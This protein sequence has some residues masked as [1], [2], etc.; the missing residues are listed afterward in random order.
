[1]SLASLFIFDRKGQITVEF[2]LLHYVQLTKLI[3]SR[4]KY[5]FYFLGIT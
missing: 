4:I 2:D 3:S 5:T 1:M